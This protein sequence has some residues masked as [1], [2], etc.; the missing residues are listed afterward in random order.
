MKSATHEEP[1]IVA[2]AERKMAAWVKSAEIQDRAVLRQEIERAAE[3]VH[4]Y[5]AIS[6]QRAA[7]G[8]RIAELLGQKLGWETLNRNLLERVA[9]RF[10]LSLS[11]LKMVDETTPNWAHDMFGTWLDRNVVSSEKYIVRLGCVVLAAVREANLVLVGR[12]VQFLLPR[13]KGVAV[14]IVAPEKVRIRTLAQRE[15][16]AETAAKKALREADRGR[17]EFVR[18]YFH[19]DVD[20]PCLY[21]LTINA[22]R[23]DP[24]TAVEQ[25]AAIVSR[26]TAS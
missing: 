9:E 4:P 17:N 16:I 13:E 19:H 10:D 24:E 1:K 22:E 7:G 15:G 26:R 21:D 12:G 3:G 8:G 20:D 5:V 6:R 18:R 2:A 14:R 11:S 23:V 25:I